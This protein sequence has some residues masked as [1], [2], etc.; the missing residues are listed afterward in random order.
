MQSTERII[1]LIAA[2]KAKA[3]DPEIPLVIVGTYKK[4]RN[5]KNSARN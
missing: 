5:M 2:T 1:R 4:V 3:G